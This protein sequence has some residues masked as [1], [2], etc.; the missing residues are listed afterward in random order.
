MSFTQASACFTQASACFI[1]LPRTQ[2]QIE[3]DNPRFVLPVVSLSFDKYQVETKRCCSI[4][5]ETDG[6]LVKHCCCNYYSHIDCIK[7][8][9]TSVNCFICKKEYVNQKIINSLIDNVRWCN[10]LGIHLFSRVEIDIGGDIITIYD[11]DNLPIPIGSAYH[12][13]IL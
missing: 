8:F 1:P 10:N 4:C 11:M 5:L 7:K 12:F 3:N 2:F 6:E 9:S 13:Q